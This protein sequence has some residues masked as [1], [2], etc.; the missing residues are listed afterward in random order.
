MNKQREDRKG[1][2]QTERW[3][4]HKQKWTVYV[5]RGER[6]RRAHLYDLNQ[7]NKYI[8]NFFKSD[9]FFFLNFWP[10]WEACRI[11]VPQPGIESMAPAFKVWGLN[12]WT[13]RGSLN[14]V[15]IAIIRSKTDVSMLDRLISLCHDRQTYQYCPRGCEK[16]NQ[17][18]WRRKV[19]YFGTAP[20]MQKSELH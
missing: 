14:S 16:R 6:N 7:Y 11:F 5:R 18:G 19:S 20:K 9:L 17:T 15:S 1:S 4:K 8:L 12:H 13:T 3:S 10:H 2:R